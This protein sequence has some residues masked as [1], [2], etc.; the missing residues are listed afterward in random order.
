MNRVICTT[1]SVLI[2]VAVVFCFAGAAA[3]QGPQKTDACTLLTQAEIQAAIGQT[4]G[5]GKLNL[6]ANPAVGQPCE[7]VVGSYGVFSI[8]AKTAGPGETADKMM[9][10]L[11]KRKT[12]VS[13][14]PGVGDRSFFASPGYGMLQ[15]N[16]FKGSKYLIITMLVPGSTEAAQKTAAKKLMNKALTRI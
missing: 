6:K 3:A 2:A 9:A 7:Y 5:I 14:A 11:K 13:D 8:L 15:L 16:T 1:R 4:V 12:A 10:E